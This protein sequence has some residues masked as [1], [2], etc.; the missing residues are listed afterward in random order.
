MDHAIVSRERM[1]RRAQGAAPQGARGDPRRST[2]CAPSAGRCPGSTVDKD[3]V[4]AGPDGDVHPRR[5]LRRAQPARDLP[6]H[7]GAGVAP[8]LPRLL[9][10]R[11]PRRRRAAGTSST[12]T[13]PSPRCRGRRSRR[14]RQVKARM[15]WTFRWVSAHDSAFNYDFAV[16]F[17]PE[18]RAAGRAI[19]NY[20]TPI[21][22][23][24]EMFGL[25]V[26][27]K[28]ATGAIHHSLFDLPPRHRAADGRL[29]LARPRPEGAQ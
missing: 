16:S 10:H 26:F 19:Y 17:P 24:G 6:L 1:A 14:S 13:S 5:P 11:R 9:V 22:D 4:F 3:Y 21:R 28:D 12:P 27:V 7:A 8:P 29:Q 23:S 2:P 18:D 25:S 15:G 20:G